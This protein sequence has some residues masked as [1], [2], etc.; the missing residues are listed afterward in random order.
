MYMDLTSILILIF[1]FYL[2][3]FNSSFPPVFILNNMTNAYYHFPFVFLF[4]IILDLFLVFRYIVEKRFPF[5]LE[6][7]RPI[8]PVYERPVLTLSHIQLVNS[9]IPSNLDIFLLSVL[10]QKITL[11]AVTI[12]LNNSLCILVILF[13]RIFNNMAL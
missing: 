11:A 13:G 1:Y 4:K 6:I 12:D 3:I 5:F 8:C 9:S 10:L 7:P 2:N